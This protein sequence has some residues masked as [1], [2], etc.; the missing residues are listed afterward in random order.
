MKR[1]TTHPGR[2]LALRLICLLSACALVVCAAAAAGPRAAGVDPR[3]PCGPAGQGCAR[4][5]DPLAGGTEFLKTGLERHGASEHD[6]D[7]PIGP[8]PIEEVE[9]AFR[10]GRPEVRAWAVAQAAARLD[11]AGDALLVRALEDA[12]AQ[13]ADAALLALAAREDARL[14]ARL[15]SLTRTKDEATRA[16]A[17]ELFGRSVGDVPFAW[18]RMLARDRDAEVRRCAWSALV[19]RVEAGRMA[20]ASAK[21]GAS[22]AELEERRELVEL[23]R[24]PASGREPVL[25][26]LAQR[27]MHRLD[28]LQAEEVARQQLAAR[29][30]GL[31]AASTAALTAATQVLALELARPLLDDDEPAVRSAAIAVLGTLRHRSAL[32]AMAARLERETQP[33]LRHRLR[34]ELARTLGVDAGFDAAAWLERARDWRGDLATGGGRA[35]VAP[36]GRAHFSGLPLVSDRIAFLVDL[37][38]SMWSAKV[39]EHTRKELVDRALAAALESLPRGARVQLVPYTAAPIPWEARAVPVD[40]ARLRQ[41]LEWFAKRHDTGPGDFLEAFELA[42]ADPEIDSVCVLTDGVPTGGE[43]HDL[44]LLFDRLA[45]KNTP[46]QLAVDALLVG[47]PRSLTVRWE[48]WCARTGGTTRRIQVEDL[49]GAESKDAPARAGGRAGG[50]DAGRAPAREPGAGDRP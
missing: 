49:L 17:A 42:L 14:L 4:D 29:D 26:H 16:R 27:L 1:C 33:R 3:G 6:T 47:C 37:S 22:L 25:A 35:V 13:P 12:H 30:P 10:T 36:Q 38:G 11:A 50:R 43:R 8:R 2:E 19:R 41:A 32:L 21:E 23:A 5:V 39:G 31:R 48:E 46:R 7:R 18:L 20:G 9:A 40:A 34:L 44:G 45:D 24:G 15:E 28:P